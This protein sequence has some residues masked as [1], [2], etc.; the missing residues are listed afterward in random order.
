MSRPLTD[1][2]Q[3]WNHG[4]S[5]AFRQLI[6]LVHDELRRVAQHLMRSEQP[7]HTLQPTALVNEAYLR[8]AGLDSVEWQS[9]NH[10]LGVAAH[11]MR[12]VTIQHARRRCAQKRGG[13]LQKV[14]AEEEEL[15]WERANELVALEEA[16]LELANLDPVQSRLVELRFFAGLTIDETATA[17]SLSRS[18]VKREWRLA[19]AWL[20]TQLDVSP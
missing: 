6:P 11:L 18:T 12:Q 4:D 15:S 16:L 5:E 2:L 8:I 10:F 20:Q 3:R 14:D 17:L 9:R 19:K 1:L 13:H 7:G